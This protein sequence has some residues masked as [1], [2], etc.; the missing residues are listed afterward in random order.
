MTRTCGRCGE[1]FETL[2]RLRLHDCPAEH[3]DDEDDT[4]SVG[5]KSAE[6]YERQSR[7]RRSSRTKRARRAIGTSF[8]TALEAAEAGDSQTVYRMLAQYEQHLENAVDDRDRYWKLHDGL[9]EPIA[10][11]LESITIEEGWPYLLDIVDAYWPEVQLSL[12]RYADPTFERYYTDDRWYSHVSHVLT[13][14]TGRLVV[15]TR[16]DEGVEAI[17]ATALEFLFLHHE[18]SG[19]GPWVESM[20][21]GWGI[22]HPS[23]P[24]EEHLRTVVAGGY[25][26]WAGSVIGHALH[27]DPHAATDLLEEVF[28]TEPP[29]DPAMLLTEAGRIDRGVYPAEP[30]Y[31]DWESVYPEFTSF[32]WDPTVERRLRD[33]VVESGIDH[34]LP[35]G[36]DLRDVEV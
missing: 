36:W 12:D 7:K 25:E 19:E 16:L 35:D 5:N 27:A 2:S 30:R 3:S 24:F 20:P 11:V 15:R 6:Q 34:Y 9:F 32:E 1:R 10:D 33:L 18:F 21:Y 17:P 22:G 31:W 13:A 4:L 26:V 28:D 8:E 29:D 23:H 14:G